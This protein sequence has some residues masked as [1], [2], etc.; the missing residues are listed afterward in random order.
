VRA[1]ISFPAVM[2]V[3]GA[4]VTLDGNALGFAAGLIL[5]P[6]QWTRGPNGIFRGRV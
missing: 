2:V 5:L 1:Y 4:E 3:H 6:F